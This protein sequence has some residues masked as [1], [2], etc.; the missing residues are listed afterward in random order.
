M[1]R[2]EYLLAC[3]AEECDEV[4]QR[5]MKALRF[6]LTEVQPGQTL[7]NADR[8]FGELSDLYAVAQLLQKEGLIGVG[9]TSLAARDAKWAKVEKFYAYSKVLGI[10]PEE[11]THDGGEGT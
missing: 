10:V 4:G 8:I 5:C 2:A 7:T 1:T 6:G 11:P 3:L 9:F